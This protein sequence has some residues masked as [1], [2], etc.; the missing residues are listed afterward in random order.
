MVNEK[1]QPFAQSVNRL[2]PKITHPRN[3]AEDTR[4]SSHRPSAPLLEIIALPD[5]SVSEAWKFFNWL[6]T[7]KW[8]GTDLKNAVASEVKGYRQC[9]R[10]SPPY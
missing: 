8:I 5:G 3:I 6:S 9:S 7:R 1:T 2:E 10:E 4:F